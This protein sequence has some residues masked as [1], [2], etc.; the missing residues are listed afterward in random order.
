MKRITISI[1]TPYAVY[2]LWNISYLEGSDCVRDVIYHFDIMALSTKI[3]KPSMLGFCLS[4]CY[5][6][7]I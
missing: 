2:E 5:S 4:V 3:K 1:A 6:V 7:F